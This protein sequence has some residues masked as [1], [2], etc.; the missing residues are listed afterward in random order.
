MSKNYTRQHSEP[1]KMASKKYANIESSPIVGFEILNRLKDGLKERLGSGIE[2]HEKIRDS[3]STKKDSNI[4]TFSGG[5]AYHVLLLLFQNAVNYYQSSMP[6]RARLVSRRH[7]H[8]A[9]PRNV[10]AYVS[11]LG[12]YTPITALLLLL[13]RYKD[14]CLCDKGA[15]ALPTP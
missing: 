10:H 2:S 1:I 3:E 4:F 12:A 13:F 5:R 14:V 6:P 15:V 7:W 9:I 11:Y 8:E